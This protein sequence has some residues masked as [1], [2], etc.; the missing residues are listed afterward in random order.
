MATELVAQDAGF[1]VDSIDLK[2]LHLALKK[3]TAEA[4]EVIVKLL[5]SNDEK[6]RLTAAKML[7]D[8]QVVVAKE[9]S[10]DQVS[11][12]I[13]EIRLVRGA[14]KGRIAEDDVH[15]PLVNFSDIREP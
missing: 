11:R 12:L 3:H 7:L 6:T 5:G 9:I 13:A 4:V 2:K 10:A 8:F 14:P 1:V 15:P